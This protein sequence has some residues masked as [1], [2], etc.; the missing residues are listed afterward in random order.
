[1]PNNESIDGDIVIDDD[2]SLTSSINPLQ[3]VIL[4]I[5]GVDHGNEAGRNEGVNSE[6]E[7]VD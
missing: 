5:E 4:D 7:G 1:M 3:N 6:N 2:D